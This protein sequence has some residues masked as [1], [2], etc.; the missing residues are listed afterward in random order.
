LFNMVRNSR[1]DNIGFPACIKRTAHFL[2]IGRRL[3]FFDF[4]YQQ[5]NFFFMVSEKE[6]TEVFPCQV[7]CNGRS[8]ISRRSYYCYSFPCCHLLCLHYKASSIV[9][10]LPLSRDKK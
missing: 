6:Q 5:L 4:I 3:C 1:N 10:L 7:F 8:H 9:T 2:H